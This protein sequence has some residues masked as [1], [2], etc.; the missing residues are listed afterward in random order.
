MRAGAKPRRPLRHRQQRTRGAEAD[1]HEP[2][3]AV[4][5]DLQR[6]VR[7]RPQ[8]VRSQSHA[9]RELR[10]REAKGPQHG[11]EQ[12][13]LLEAVAAAS[14]GD[15]LRLQTV[16]IERDRAA[17]QDVE[18]LERDVRD[19]RLVQRLEHRARRLALAGVLDADADRRE[20]RG[21]P[22]RPRSST[23][24][25]AHGGPQPDP[26][27]RLHARYLARM[28]RHGVRRDIHCAQEAAKTADQ[29]DHGTDKQRAREPLEIG[30]EKG[31][32]EERRDDDAHEEGRGRAEIDRPARHVAPALEIRELLA[33]EGARVSSS[34]SQACSK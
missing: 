31:L 2:S 27:T 17:Q 12:Q 15:E 24:P 22:I 19:V 3:P 6:H 4:D 23:A 1:I 20:G 21:L 11:G 10:Y 7:P 9:S 34:L 14:P 33:R 16:E 8:D 18:I 28:M 29:R 5:V 26:A 13:V 32:D 30:A 25:F